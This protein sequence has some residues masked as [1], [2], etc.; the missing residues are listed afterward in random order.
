MRPETFTLIERDDN[1]TEEQQK[2]VDFIKSKNKSKFYFN[3]FLEVFPDKG[4]R[5]VKKVLTSMV[6]GEILEFWSS[7]S[8]TMY[9]L[10]GG[11]KD[12]G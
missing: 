2:I 5:D 11:T 7:G 12:V 10:K 6:Q 1:M 9:A 4:P 8:T 3:D